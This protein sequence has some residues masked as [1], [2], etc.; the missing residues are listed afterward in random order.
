M[1]FY[2]NLYLFFNKVKYLKIFAIYLPKKKLAIIN[3]IFC[4]NLKYF[5]TY[6]IYNKKKKIISLLFHIF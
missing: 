5:I 3:R 6:D 4:N 1:D 2:N